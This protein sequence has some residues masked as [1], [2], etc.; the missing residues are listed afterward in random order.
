[1][2]ALAVTLGVARGALQHGGWR[3]WEQL[4]GINGGRLRDR[5]PRGPDQTHGR[6][7][8]DEQ[9]DRIL[10]GVPNLPQF[11]DQEGIDTSK[12]STPALPAISSR[13]ACRICAMMIVAQSCC[14]IT[15][16]LALQSKELELPFDELDREFMSSA[17]HRAGDLRA[18]TAA[19]QAW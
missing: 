2:P 11:L 7:A 4:A 6:S 19:N 3:E 15:T 18:S 13:N 1:M 5:T 16:G 9:C 17:G 14:S 12:G 10:P 8:L